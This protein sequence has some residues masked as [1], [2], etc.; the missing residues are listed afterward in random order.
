MLPDNIVPARYHIPT[1]ETQP[2]TD[3][4]SENLT[5]GKPT[6]ADYESD[7]LTSK[8]RAGQ[9]GN[10]LLEEHDRHIKERLFCV[11]KIE[12]FAKVLNGLVEDKTINAEELAE[13][14][15]AKTAHINEAG[16]KIWLNLITREKATPLFYQFE[17]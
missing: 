6:L 14:I 2:A 4:S 10:M 7:I 16:N 1:P 3:E 13:L 11:V 12:T 17:D 8:S 15:A 9:S 5:K